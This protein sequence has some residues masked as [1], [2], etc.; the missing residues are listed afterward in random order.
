MTQTRPPTPTAL[1]AGRRD[2]PGLTAA[3]I[4]L[5]TAG[6]Q[7]AI[8]AGAPLGRF[9]YGGGHT[10]ALA[11]ALRVTSA[12][13]VLLYVAVAAVSYG[14]LLRGRPRRIVLRIVSVLFL[15]G[16]VTNALSK[17]LWETLI[18]VPVSLALSVLLW[19]SSR[20]DV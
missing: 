12:V 14:L 3:V 10:A 13:A 18:W 20:R 11:P 9:S 17:S 16:V 5:C 4:L 1:T 15:L 2:I 8:A 19:M 7:L 6:F